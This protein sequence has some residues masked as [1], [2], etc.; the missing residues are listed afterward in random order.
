MKEFYRGLKDYSF[1]CMVNWDLNKNKK[2]IQMDK[3]FKKLGK[4]IGFKTK[5]CFSYD[6]GKYSTYFSWAEKVPEKKGHIIIFQK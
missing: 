1:L 6:I 3:K 5:Q 4:N 2:L